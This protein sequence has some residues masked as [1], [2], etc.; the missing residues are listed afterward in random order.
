MKKKPTLVKIRT[1]T[2]KRIVIKYSYV[3]VYIFYISF[4]IRVVRTNTYIYIIHTRRQ[5]HGSVFRKLYIYTR[6]PFMLYLYI[7]YSAQVGILHITQRCR[8]YYY[9]YYFHDELLLARLLRCPVAASC[10]SATPTYVHI[11]IYVYRAHTHT[12]IY[13]LKHTSVPG[14]VV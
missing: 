5:Y 11:C 1:T 12:H 13:T 3:Y 4:C 14:R 2:R 9:Y 8:I 7:I 6:F 10:V